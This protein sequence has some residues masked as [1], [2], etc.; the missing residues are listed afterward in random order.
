VNQRLSKKCSALLWLLLSVPLLTVAG[1]KHNTAEQVSDQASQTALALPELIYDSS[2]HFSDIDSVNLDG[3]LERIGDSRLV[4]LGEASHGTAEFY[5]MR[6]RIT[7]ELIEKKG[8]N[9]IAVEAD[10]P[11][12]ETIDHFVRAT[13]HHPASK[14]KPFSGFPSWMWANHSVLAFVHWL[15]DYNQYFNSAEDAVA[16]YGLDFYNI[17][18][19]I[20]AVLDYLQDVDPGTAEAARWSYGC[21]MPWADDPSSYGRIMRSGRYRGC[22]Y[23]VQLVLQ[24]LRK[25]RELYRHAFRQADSEEGR[26]RY[27]SA[28]QNA[29]Q[30]TKAERFYRTMYRANN[31]SW[32]QRDQSMFDT[33]LEILNY[34]GQT[35]KVVVW[36]HN[37]H[38]GDARATDMAIRGEFNLGQL[39]RE[40]FADSA[41]LIGF[42]TD[43]GTVAAASEWGGPMK[44]MQV[45]AS[46]KDSYESLFHEVKT[47]NFLLPLRKSKMHSPVQDITR[48]KLLPERLQR[49][50]GTAYDPEDE[51]KKH[52][53]HASLPRQFDEYIW[54]DK[55][56]AVK[57]L[58]SEP[59]KGVADT[60]PS[61]L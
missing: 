21:L 32:N 6:A 47:K 23:E 29:R 44:I 42:G 17:F 18:G 13:G 52:Y 48:D 27:F 45:P 7:R 37:S 54:F 25:K 50:I 8:F 14:N 57:P 59:V 53:S 36:A 56:R 30:I 31:N 4:L 24:D 10:W 11:D 38:I 49:A 35:S 2:E 26:Q 51:L 19:S 43:H 9:I 28:E 40:T 60:F 20:E 1:A 34:R 39:V 3:L 61:G 12:A 15:R 16:F 5:D 58:S 46:R 41:Y 55:T 33:L 22:G